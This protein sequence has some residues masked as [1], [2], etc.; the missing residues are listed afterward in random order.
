M[1]QQSRLTNAMQSISREEVRRLLDSREIILV[2]VLPPEHYERA[3]LPG[4]LN[5]PYDRIATLAPALIP[6][7]KSA[8]VV[9]GLNFTWQTAQQA[10]RELVALGYTNVREY[11][12]GKQDWV[13]AGLPLEGKNLDE[14]IVKIRPSEFVGHMTTGQQNILQQQSTKA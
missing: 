14:P 9:Y 7:K 2:E 6:N 8:L 5:I 1:R 11:E 4:T 10:V 13:A 12:E 3:H